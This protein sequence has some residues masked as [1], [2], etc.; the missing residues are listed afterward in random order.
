[1]KMFESACEERVRDIAAQERDNNEKARQQLVIECE[2]KA[3]SVV[4]GVIA[5]ARA[6]YV[7][8]DREMTGLRAE[9]TEANELQE[10]GASSNG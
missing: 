10:P 9:L 5:N 2:K 6:A 1:M 7:E 4:D 3:Q 8:K